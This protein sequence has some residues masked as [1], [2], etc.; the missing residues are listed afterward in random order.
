MA[1][2]G[3]GKTTLLAEACR[4]A[5]A[6][7]VLVAW[8]AVARDDDTA[9]LDSC[10][11]YALEAAAP[12]LASALPT[13]DATDIGAH[14]RVVLMLRILAAAK[15]PCILALDE[16]ENASDPAAVELLNQVLLNAPPCL[17][18]A[19]ACRE[20][21]PGLDASRAVLNGRAEV[22]TAADLMF[23]K[24][25]IARFFDL[26]LSRNEL[27]A[28]AAES[29]GWPIALA[30]RRN[31]TGRRGAAE[32]RVARHVID[33]WIGGRFWEGFAEVDRER[34]REIGLLDWFDARLVEEVVEDPH[35]LERLLALP[36]LAGLLESTGQNN[37]GVYRLHPLLREHC[38]ERLQ[39]DDPARYR[40]LHRR[41]AVALAR[42]EATVEAMRHARLGSDPALAGRILLDA[43][44]VR[45]WLRVGRDRL[46]AA[47][48]L[49]TDDMVTEPRL[50]MVRSIALLVQGRS[51]EAR[52][53][54]DAAARS[55]DANLAID[56]IIATGALAL[57]GCRPLVGAEL[58]ATMDE[59]IR[60]VAAPTTS[61]AVRAAALH[62]LSIYRAHR[63]EFKAAVEHARQARMLA[64][65]RSAYVMMLADV[66]IGQLAMLRGR[67]AEALRAY[68]SAQRIDREHFLEEPHLGAYPYI[69]LYELALERNR[70][71]AD[72]DHQRIAA[73]TYRGSAYLHRRAATADVAVDLALAAGGTE[74]ALAVI[75]TMSENARAA[76]NAAL[77]WHLAALQAGVLADGGR[78]AAAEAVWRAAGLPAAGSACLN[79][80]AN[81]WRLTEAL[82]CAQ[83][84]LVAASGDAQAA[85]R[86]AQQLANAA[87]ERGIVRTS[88]RALALR[89]RFCEKARERDAADAA[90]AD[91]LAFYVRT[92]YARPLVRAGA[93]AWAA[94]QRVTDGAAGGN[95]AAAA[96]RILA[97]GRD[98]VAAQPRLTDG[99]KAVLRL[100]GTE[101]DKRIAAL[102]GLSVHGVRYRIRN[103]FTKL[104]VRGRVDA[105]R[106]A[107]ALGV[108]PTTD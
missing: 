71:T 34:V 27:N 105:V 59:A 29:G 1:P 25:D 4:T 61:N 64:N 41:I 42:R 106:R 2:G 93:P 30:I 87:T 74:P 12:S 100:L 66:Q 86:L 13:A 20:L 40:H 82:T 52:S 81:G 77:D 16:L 108:L 15:R 10:L 80:S 83:I 103:I 90:V 23:S 14:P 5:A 47:H 107:R 67:V 91:Y 104:G 50:A 18:V 70:L 62:G 43:G 68:R 7:G 99:E 94:L 6:R 28:V 98:R 72:T 84:R 32:A 63:I 3:F 55:G 57:D 39:R 9:M 33:N 48:R 101:P 44:G 11:A 88:M 37:A 102:L 97:M 69:P 54:Y 76:G 73:E 60:L 45:W 36:M 24:P 95:L 79:Y 78:V 21:P 17:H 65:G 85:A 35:A 22:I 89:V 8:V 53:A 75:A 31:D 38:A 96:D 92:D 56:R 49:L 26:E 19:I 51:R 58:R 46:I